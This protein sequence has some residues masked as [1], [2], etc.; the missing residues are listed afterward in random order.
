M[1][2][3][4]MIYVDCMSLYTRSL[5]STSSVEGNLDLANHF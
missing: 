1:E 3:F 4:Q 2:D 5:I